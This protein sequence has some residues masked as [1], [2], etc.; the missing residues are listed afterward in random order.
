MTYTIDIYD[1]AGKKV[2]TKDLNAELYNDDMIHSDLVHEYFL[3]QRANGRIAIAHTKTRWEVAGTGKKMYRQKG[4]G[5]A[6]VGDKKSPIRVGGGVAF[7]PRKERN[8]SKNMSK[9]M[10]RRAL[11][12]LIAMKANE[13][14]I[15]GLNEFS[16]DQPKTKN[17]QSTLNALGCGSEKVLFVISEKTDILTKSFSNLDK[18]KY[19]LASYLNPI[20]LLHSD[21]VVVME[22]ALDH[23]NGL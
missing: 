16:F 21:K 15:V 19:I 13:G 1:V 12:S 4:T 23:I 20:D 22:N 18:A 2:S 7:G 5:S 11:L 17:A 3:L 8:F 9:K 14:A 10:R 6:R